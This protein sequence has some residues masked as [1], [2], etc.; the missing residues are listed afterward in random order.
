MNS[1]AIKLLALAI[2]AVAL[3]ALL[4][5]QV[6]VRRDPIRRERRRRQEVYLTGR[7]VEGMVLDLDDSC[8]HY[9]YTVNSVPYSTAQDFST[10]EQYLPADRN[11]MIGEVRVKFA[12]NNPANSIVIC[13]FWSGFRAAHTATKQTS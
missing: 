6:R 4:Y 3:S 5:R 8:V 2:I 12:H 1:D 9:C 7:L 10:L 11:S 13:E